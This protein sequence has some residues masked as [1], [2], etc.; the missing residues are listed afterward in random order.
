MVRVSV[1]H[2]CLKTM[3]NAERQGKR[4]VMVRPSSKVIIKFLSVMQRH[5]YIG[6]FEIVDDHRAGK[7]VIQLTG[8]LNKCGVISP[9]FPIKVTDIEQ[10]VSDLLPSRLFGYIVMTTSAG[11]MDHEEA[12]RRH[13][14]G[15]ILGYFY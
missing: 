10:W 9:R 12:R 11:I 14:G 1:L 2:D 13:V 15:K 7:I 6:E 8:R 3:S 4:Q 5:G